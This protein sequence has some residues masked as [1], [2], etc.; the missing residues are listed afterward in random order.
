MRRASVGD[1]RTPGFSRAIRVVNLAKLGSEPDH[2]AAAGDGAILQL[3]DHEVLICPA[4]IPE[5]PS[6]G[7]IEAESPIE[8][9]SPSTTTKP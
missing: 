8:A 6:V 3:Q 4:F 7:P 2:T 9:G 5:A 1:R